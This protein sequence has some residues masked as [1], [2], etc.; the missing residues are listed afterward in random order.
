M[1]KAITTVVE[2]KKIGRPTVYNEKIIDEI[3]ARIAEGEAL[4]KIVQDEHMPSIRSV[5]RWL[6]D[7]NFKT[8]WHKYAE[9]RSTQAEK[10]F[11][12]LLDIADEDVIEGD[13]KSDNARVQ[14]QKLRVDARKWYLSKVLPKKFG[15]KLDLTSHG[16]KLPAPILANINLI[17]PKRER[18]KVEKLP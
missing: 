15:D 6:L 3:C 2:G 8:F 17:Q 14:R 4:I 9:A 7:E 5:F 16:D 12:E 18:K 10:M 11:E 13:D 1:T